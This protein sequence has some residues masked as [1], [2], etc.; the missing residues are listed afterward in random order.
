MQAASIFQNPGQYSHNCVLSLCLS[1]LIHQA[2]TANTFLWGWGGRK[3][4][5]EFV[6]VIITITNHFIFSK[7][8]KAEKMTLLGFKA[9]FP[10]KLLLFLAI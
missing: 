3:N 6:T 2:N 8:G 9:N 10:M 5:T 4:V 7:L 1:S